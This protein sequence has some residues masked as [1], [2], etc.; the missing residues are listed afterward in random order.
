MTQT[1]TPLPAADSP[2]GEA[3]LLDFVIAA[4]QATGRIPAPRPR[5]GLPEHLNLDTIRGLHVA[6]Q[7][8]GWGANVVFDAPAGLPNTLGTPD[9]HPCPT[10]LDGFL[11]GAVI[12]CEVLTGSRKLP[13]LVVGDRLICAAR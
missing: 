9:A 4:L 6:P 7:G 5:T 8:G 1:T 3:N 2:D 10:P 11:L 12:V 13:F